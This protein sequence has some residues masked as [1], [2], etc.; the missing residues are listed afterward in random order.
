MVF[1]IPN[2]VVARRKHVDFNYKL[3]HSREKNENLEII[4]MWLKQIFLAPFKDGPFGMGLL[5]WGVC[6][7]YRDASET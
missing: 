6:N 2:L 7:A 5:G 1:E 3:K 4:L